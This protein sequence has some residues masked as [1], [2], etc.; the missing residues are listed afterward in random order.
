MTATRGV[1]KS[2]AYYYRS[3]S[4]AKTLTDNSLLTRRETEFSAV[5]LQNLLYLYIPAFNPG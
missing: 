2:A 1:T 4:G 5:S 3:G